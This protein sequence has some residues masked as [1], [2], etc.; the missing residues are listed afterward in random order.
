MNK[1]N[2]SFLK[3]KKYYI[4]FYNLVVYILDCFGETKANA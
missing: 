4:N 1:R 3:I 2:L